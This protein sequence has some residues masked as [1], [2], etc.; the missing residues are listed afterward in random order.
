VYYYGMS[1]HAYKMRSKVWLWPGETAAWHFMTLPLKESEEIKKK[2]GDQRRG[3]G[4]IPVTVTIGTTT[5]DTSLFPDKRSG[6]YLLPLKAKVRQAEGV[7][8][9]DTVTFSL[10]VR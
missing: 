2:H 6:C 10:T 7:A 4:S 5:W 8:M 9:D 1:K 3:F